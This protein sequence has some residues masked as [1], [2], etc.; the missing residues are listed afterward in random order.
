MT[1]NYEISSSN[2][3]FGNDV[4]E[5]NGYGER[6]LKKKIFNTFISCLVIHLKRKKYTSR[7]QAL[8]K[9]KFKMQEN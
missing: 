4:V 3:S 1:Q 6:H 8:C 9:F 5:I 7:Q 2:Q